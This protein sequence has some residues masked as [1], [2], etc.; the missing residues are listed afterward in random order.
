MFTCGQGLLAFTV[1]CIVTTAFF[2]KREKDR[3]ERF[4]ER[5]NRLHDVLTQK[6][7]SKGRFIKG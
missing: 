7:D 5:V 2:I 1:G 3:D 6:R 4:I